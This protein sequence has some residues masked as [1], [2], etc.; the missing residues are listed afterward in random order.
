MGLAD[1]ADD[2]HGSSVTGETGV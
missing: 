2:A 1:S